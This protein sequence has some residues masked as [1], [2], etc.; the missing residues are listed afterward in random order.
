MTDSLKELIADIANNYPAYRDNVT[1]DKEHLV[2]HLVTSEFPE[3]I[4]PFVGTKR[5]YKIQGSTGQGR[6]TQAPWVAVFDNSITSSAQHGYYIVYLY[7]VTLN[8]IFLTLG[9]AVTDFSKIYGS[10]RTML[11]GI[12]G[13]CAKLGDLI[14]APD[15]VQ[16]GKI[17]L[18]TKGASNL[19]TQYAHG[20]IASIEYE[21]SNLPNDSRLAADLEL[22][23]KL[24]NDLRLKVGPNILEDEAIS[25]AAV[26]EDVE[27]EAKDFTR[28]EPPKKN[29]DSSGR[30][31]PRQSKQAKKTGDAGEQIVI[32]YEQKRLT[33]GGRP[34]LADQIVW[35]ADLNQFPGY[36][37]SSFNLDG[38][39]RN[40]EVKASTGDEI[41]SIT[42]TD[43]EKN[44]ATSEDRN[45]YYLYLV[46]SV[47]KKPT[48]EILH[49]PAD[50]T[51]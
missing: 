38:S 19:H 25:E 5:N 8:Q 37:I 35:E 42:L 6:I 20:C 29:N 14:S 51:I 24:Y 3:K 1:V 34:D 45:A 46:T 11:K 17:D 48:I 43:N 49:N 13:T 23:V 30:S 18:G 33:D 31:T 32:E 15:R 28:K 21:I 36:D 41:N 16:K 12:E 22:F 39:P 4:K 26:P 10:N 7:N 44:A 47:F 27:I 2:Y 40:I 9:A 50:S